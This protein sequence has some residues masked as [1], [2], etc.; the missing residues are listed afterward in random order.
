MIQ[1]L[2]LKAARFK[3]FVGEGLPAVASED[4][5]MV[6]FEKKALDELIDTMKPAGGEKYRKEV[7]KMKIKE[8]KAREKQGSSRPMGRF[9]RMKKNTPQEDEAIQQSGELHK[10]SCEMEH[11]RLH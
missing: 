11:V 10:F 9:E 3:H 8:E 4:D 5:L 6:Y 7:E 1:D 2:D